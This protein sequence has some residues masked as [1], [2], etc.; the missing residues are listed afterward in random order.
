M[1]CW[2]PGTIWCAN[3]CASS[4]ALIARVP[5]IA[6]AGRRPMTDQGGGAEAVGCN[7]HNAGID[8]NQRADNRALGCYWM[9]RLQICGD[10]LLDPAQGCWRRRFRG[11][12]RIERP[13]EF[14]A[15]PAL[16]QMLLDLGRQS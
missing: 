16:A 12:G 1:R 4:A 14:P 3:E 15:S 11:H 9:H 10:G 6:P 2:L 8:C 5:K 13:Q 7:S